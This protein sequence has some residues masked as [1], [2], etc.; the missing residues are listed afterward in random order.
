[1]SYVPDSGTSYDD[2]T[3][4]VTQPTGPHFTI[5]SVNAPTSVSTGKQF[6]ITITVANDGNDSGDVTIRLYENDNLVETTTL[7]L[8]AG[9]QGQASFTRQAPNS[10]TTLN[11]KVEAYNVTNDT[12]DDQKT[13]TVQVTQPSTTGVGTATIGLIIL[14]ILLLL[15]F[16]L[17]RK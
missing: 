9:E 10:P 2:I 7:T 15:I 14:I 3:V 12:V 16:L 6:T 5:A 13:F 11:Y 4:E 17:R 8:S 1:M